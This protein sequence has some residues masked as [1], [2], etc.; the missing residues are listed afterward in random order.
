MGIFVFVTSYIVNKCKL[1][2]HHKLIV[3]QLLYKNFITT[4]TSNNNDKVRKTNK[5]FINTFVGVVYSS[6][7]AAIVAVYSSDL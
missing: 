6:Q 5:H 3:V 2:S 4:R 1:I 7:N